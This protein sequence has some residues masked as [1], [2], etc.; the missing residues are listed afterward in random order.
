LRRSIFAWTGTQTATPSYGSPTNEHTP[1]EPVGTLS[2]WGH[3]AD[4]NDLRRQLA[5][6]P[7]TRFGSPLRPI[8]HRL[9][10]R[11]RAHVL[12][13]VLAWRLRKAWAPMTFTDEHPS[14]RDIP[15]APKQRSASA[16]A[17]GPPNT[18]P[19]APR[20]AASSACL[21][22]W[23]PSPATRSASPAPK[24]PCSPTHRRSAPRLRPHRRTHPPHRRVVRHQRR[25]SN[26]SPAQRGIRTTSPLQ[27]RPKKAEMCHD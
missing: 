14:Q 5:P 1:V 11:V 6:I 20:C 18:T 17:K 7:S 24:S 27:L 26:K 19:P 9:D 3:R 23:P 8:H 13:C 16:D 22:T 25:Q 15:V 21:L 12:I 4:G 10:D 2:A